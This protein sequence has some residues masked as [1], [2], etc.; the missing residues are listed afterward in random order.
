MPSTTARFAEE[1]GSAVTGPEEV[2]WR[3]RIRAELDNFRAA[4]N[5]ALDRGDSEAV[6]AVR[7]VA[8]LT[9]EA[10]L[11]L[12]SGI[13]HWAGRVLPHTSGASPGLRTAVLAAAAQDALGRDDLETARKLALEATREGFPDDCPAPTCAHAALAMAYAYTMR[14]DL[15][16][17]VI[18]EAS[19]AAGGD[20]YCRIALLA[21][22]ATLHT[23]SADVAARREADEAVQLARQL[24][25]PSALSDALYS[26]SWA[27]LS[28]EPAALDALEECIALTRSGASDGVFSG[29]LAQAARL[30]A[31]AG[32]RLGALEALQEAIAHAY[33]TGYRR[34]VIFALSNAIEVLI[35]VGCPEPA[36]VL[37]GW[38]GR[39][40]LSSPEGTLRAA[41]GAEP[42]TRATSRGAAMNFDEVVSFVQAQIGE[43]LV[44]AHATSK[45]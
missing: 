33:Q 28:D 26:F 39:F 12:S 5:W 31:R 41:L 32:D 4:V 29:A 9:R 42:Y 34:A 2:R 44:D 16:L 8:A 11:N 38:P 40:A 35:Q 17:K 22:A 27:Y 6:S 43:L 1:A 19:E 10:Q 21:R 15:A 30:R 20:L 36:A 45:T 3:R 25:N 13:G 14:V 18:A 24:G 23:W 7:I 37:S